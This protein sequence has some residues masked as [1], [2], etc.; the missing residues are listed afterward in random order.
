MKRKRSLFFLE[1]KKIDFESCFLLHVHVSPPQCKS[2]WLGCEIKMA[3]TRYGMP[4]L[5]RVIENRPPSVIT[6][7]QSLSHVAGMDE[8]VPEEHPARRLH[9]R[10][11]AR[12]QASTTPIWRQEVKMRGRREAREKTCSWEEKRERSDSEGR[13]K[14]STMVLMSDDTSLR[15]SHENAMR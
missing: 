13:G 1:I 12:K 3:R 9:T 15:H 10:E 11:K 2:T 14:A 4:A 5:R 8:R 6:A 7:M